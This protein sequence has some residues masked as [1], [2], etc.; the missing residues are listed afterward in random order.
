MMDQFIAFGIVGLST[1]AIYAIISSGLV[2]TYATTGVFNFAHGA[3]GMMAAFAYWQL[4][5]GWGWPVWLALPVILVVLAPLFGILVEL[6]MR[7]VQGLGDAEKL[8]MTIAL[9]S[10]LIALARWI[11][12]P[13]EPRSLPSFFADRTPFHIGSATVSWHQAMTM[14]IAIAVALALRVLLFN[15]RTGVEMRATVDDRALV[16]LTGANPVR[17][18]RVAWVAGTV[19][20]A[21]GGVLIASMVSLDA[22]QLSLLIVSAYAAA[23]FGRLTSLPM[24]FVGAIVVGCMEAYLAGYLPQNEYLPGLRL[25]APAILL[26]IALLIFP[27]RKLRGRERNLTQVP[28]PTVRG[29]IVF[30]VVIVVFGLMLATV[31]GE[32]DLITYGQIFA[33]GV[34]ALSMVPLIGYAGQISLAQ[35][36]IAGIGAVVCANFGAEGQWWAIP[37][38]MLVAGAIGALVALPALRLS[39]VYLALGTGAIAVVLDRWIFPMASLEL[40]GQ[41][42]A[43]FNMGSANLVGPSLFGFHL[44]STAELTVFA[45]VCLALAT[46]LV[47]AIRRGKLGRRLI[48]LRDSE[49]AY[50]TF[51]GSLLLMKTLVFAISAA[52]AGLGGALYG[53]QLQAVAPEQFN[54]VAGLGIFLIAVV[55]GLGVV[56]NGLFTGSMIAGPMNA[57]VA[58]IPA[59]QN[60]VQTLP[61]LAGLAYGSGSV[62]DGVVPSLRERFDGA[63]RNP[64]AMGSLA[65]AVVVLWMLRL[66]DL[67]NGYVLVLGIAI[68]A[69]A[70]FGLGTRRGPETYSEPEVPVEWWGLQRPW[71]END[72]EVLER[73]IATRG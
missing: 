57:L 43:F 22:M 10:G 63:L 48:A 27:H 66:A 4:S 64:I 71:D 33:F 17:A 70:A 36:G 73:A 39:G 55:G 51:G 26:L 13:M 38:A 3:T 52:I 58:L 20:A 45:A 32:G 59:T 62:D 28:V 67:I 6:L 16:G 5:V 21:L 7:P 41:E 31:L 24:T 42:F 2:V 15:T 30:A 11:W 14:V 50:A 47:A 25:A 35:L 65:V 72:E 34:I 23:I 60:F 19:L 69:A 56:G 44:D 46:A 29:T 53:M 49:T 37:L 12:D 9:L 68:A 54:F 61:A 40:F 8:V 18:N 1:A